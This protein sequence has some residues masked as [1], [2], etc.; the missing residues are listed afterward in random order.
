[1]IVEQFDPRTSNS[2]QS[3]T[4]TLYIPS[5]MIEEQHQDVITSHPE[6]NRAAKVG[7]VSLI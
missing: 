6:E 3:Q 1:M 7:F 2:A 4:T 5:K